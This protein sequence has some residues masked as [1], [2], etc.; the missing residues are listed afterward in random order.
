[1]HRFSIQILCCLSFLSWLSEWTEE[2]PFTRE[3]PS[4]I[5]ASFQKRIESLGTRLQTEGRKT[6]SDAQA[7]YD[8]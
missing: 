3:A 1:M 4:V 8:N 7:K 2:L 5:A 6:L